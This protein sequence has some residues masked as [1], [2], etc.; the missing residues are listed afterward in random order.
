MQNRLARRERLCLPSPV[1]T[2]L[3]V[4]SAASGSFPER[5]PDEHRETTGREQAGVTVKRGR[6]CR[7]SPVETP[8]LLDRPSIRGVG[9]GGQ[10]PAH[11]PTQ[12]SGRAGDVDGSSAFVSFIEVPFSSFLSHLLGYLY[13]TNYICRV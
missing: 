10:L 9:V 13:N 11:S 3:P 4:P 1:G 7:T 5:E 8:A 2:R 6:G 12:T